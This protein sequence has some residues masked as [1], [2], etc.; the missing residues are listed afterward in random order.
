MRGVVRSGFKLDPAASEPRGDGFDHL[1][2]NLVAELKLVS[3]A[4]YTVL[5]T[6]L[7]RKLDRNPAVH[8]GCVDYI[9]THAFS[10]L[11]G[12]SVLI[13]EQLIPSMIY[14]A[15]KEVFGNVEDIFP[16]LSDCTIV[17][18]DAATSISYNRTLWDN[19]IFAVR[20]SGQKVDQNLSDRLIRLATNSIVADEKTEIDAFVASCFPVIF[21]ALRAHNRRW[22]ADADKI[23]DIFNN[24]KTAFPRIGL[25]L[26]GHG[27]TSDP[28][29]DALMAEEEGML[30]AITGALDPDLPHFGTA[31]KPL[32]VSVYAASLS[33]C[34]LSSQGTT[35]TK[36]VLIANKPG[37]LVGPCRFPWDVLACRENPA[38]AEEL[39][40][41]SVE[42][43]PGSLTS[44]FILP[45][46]EVEAALRRVIQGLPLRATG[47]PSR[48][49]DIKTDGPGETCAAQ[50]T[51]C[52]MTTSHE[53]DVE[54]I[55]NKDDRKLIPELWFFITWHQDVTRLFSLALSLVQP[56]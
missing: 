4:N 27:Q 9:S 40:K 55:E 37:V 50:D 12:L 3:V 46:A 54:S 10:E 18:P 41:A 31:G 6:Y 32:A 51:R 35:A 44:D 56:K 42:T 25:I 33:D 21:I 29:P 36:S 13:R 47:R 2:R 5:S 1:L 34:Y 26:D 49:V 24:L 45:P 30:A 8:V 16:E 38:H 7:E 52:V 19:N 48:M 20:I 53:F 14:V 11:G 28:L 17:R 15:A 43:E 23:A 22:T 39:W